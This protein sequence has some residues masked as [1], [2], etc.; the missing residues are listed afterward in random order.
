M[1]NGKIDKLTRRITMPKNRKR[2]IQPGAKSIAIRTKFKIGTRKSGIGANQVGSKEL[3][4]MLATVPKRD[5]SMLK[6]IIA[7]R[8]AR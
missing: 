4:E 5:R 7:N 8:N 2:V 6:Q 3:G 1:Q